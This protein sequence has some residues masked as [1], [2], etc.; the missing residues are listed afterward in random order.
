MFSYFSTFNGTFS[1][2]SKHFAPGPRNCVAGFD[3]EPSK[4]NLEQGRDTTRL[5]FWKNISRQSVPV[6][7]EGGI[8][9][10]KVDE[11]YVR[12]GTGRWEERD[13]CARSW[14]AEYWGW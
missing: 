7:L 6:R 5:L 8:T 13:K 3:G 10:R 11:V 2:L 9:R 14:W 12:A 1:W 4:R